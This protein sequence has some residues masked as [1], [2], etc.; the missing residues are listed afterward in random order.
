MSSPHK[1]VTY[2]ST[3]SDSASTPSNSAAPPS[4]FAPSAQPLPAFELPAPASCIPQTQPSLGTHLL[5][6]TLMPTSLAPPAHPTAPFLSHPLSTLL[7]AVQSALATSGT[8][9]APYA[10]PLSALGTQPG[11]LLGQPG[12]APGLCGAALELCGTAPGLC[13]TAP[14]PLYSADAYSIMA[15]SLPYCSSWQEKLTDTSWPGLAVPQAALPLPAGGLD[16]QLGLGKPLTRRSSSGDGDDDGGS[17]VDC[18]PAALV[19]DALLGELFFAQ[20]EPCQVNLDPK[21]RQQ[22]CVPEQ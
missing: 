21:G 2:R 5:P 13:H 18:D 6:P 19:E 16:L 8:A 1:H 11:P 14:L 10:P 20:P 9:A 4:T 22:M 12:A 3:I 7:P 15:G 17:S